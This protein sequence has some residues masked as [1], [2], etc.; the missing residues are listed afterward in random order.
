MEWVAQVVTPILCGAIGSAFGCYYDYSYVS[1]A[2]GRFL[3]RSQAEEDCLF[4]FSDH[5]R[6]LGY[7]L[8][9]G[10]VRFFSFFLSWLFLNPFLRQA[11]VWCGVVPRL[12]ESGN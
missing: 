8:P 1:Q 10:V 11:R 5:Y 6:L 3:V 9:G 4:V 7:L 2:T 12:D